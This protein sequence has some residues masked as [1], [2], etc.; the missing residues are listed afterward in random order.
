MFEHAN[1]DIQMRLADVRASETDSN[2]GF[3]Q[4]DLSM[5]ICLV[6]ASIF[7]FSS[8]SS[9]R[10]RSVLS[11]FHGFHHV[12]CRAFLHKYQSV[13]VLRRLA[14]RLCDIKTGRHQPIAIGQRSWTWISGKPSINRSKSTVS[15][16]RI[17]ALRFYDCGPTNFFSPFD[18]LMF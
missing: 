1:D 12:C 14:R 15:I 6:A 4:D 13:K 7:T 3:V 2:P 11:V 9:K 16:A 18:A 17:G 10:R 8:Q 5:P